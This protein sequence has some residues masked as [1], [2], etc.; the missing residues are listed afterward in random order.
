MQPKLWKLYTVVGIL[1]SIVM[2]GGSCGVEEESGPLLPAGLVLTRAG[3]AAQPASSMGKSIAADVRPQRARDGAAMVGAPTMG[4]TTTVTTDVNPAV[5]GQTITFSAQVGPLGAVSPGGT[6][7]FR[8]KDTMM[9]LRDCTGMVCQDCIGISIALSMGG[10]PTCPTSYSQVGSHTVLATYNGDG[11]FLPSS[12][13][14]TETVEPAETTLTLTPSWTFN[15]IGQP[16]TYTATVSPVAPGSGTPTGIFAFWKNG[17]LITDPGCTTAVCTTTFSESGLNSIVAVYRGDGNFLGSSNSYLQL[18]HGCTVQGELWAW[19]LVKSLHVSPTEGIDLREGITTIKVISPTV[20]R[21][22]S[23]G[24]P[25]SSATLSGIISSATPKSLIG[26]YV[27]LQVNVPLGSP[28][29]ATLT[30]T[31]TNTTYQVN[32]P[33]IVHNLTITPAP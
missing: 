12:G 29:S 15:D 4:S 6:V 1:A 14:Y 26:D 2:T 18:I 19:D 3:G 28:P 10:R 13:E 24:V 31:T 30:D 27:T 8:D 22:S 21:C 16:I 20:T 11:T 5:V 7:D 32:P 23:P 9:P 25:P 17:I 33:Y